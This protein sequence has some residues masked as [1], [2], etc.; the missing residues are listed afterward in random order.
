MCCRISLETSQTRSGE[1]LYL[2]LI[3]CTVSCTY[4]LT[5]GAPRKASQ[6]RLWQFCT[7][8]SS[9]HQHC[10]GIMLGCLAKWSTTR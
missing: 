4:Y 3:V 2:G 1:L 8:K 9:R 5:I 10:S 6:L 7:P